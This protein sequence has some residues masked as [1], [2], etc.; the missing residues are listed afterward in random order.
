MCVSLLKGTMAL[1]VGETAERAVVGQIRDVGVV[2]FDT[3]VD[4][5]HV[6]NTI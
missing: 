6:A 5:A 3:G 1:A 4:T 2:C